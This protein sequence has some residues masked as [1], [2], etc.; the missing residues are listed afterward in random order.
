MSKKDILHESQFIELSDVDLKE[1]LGALWERIKQLKES[2]KS[3]PD[4]QQMTERLKTYREDNF[5]SERKELEKHLKAARYVANA[6]GIK[7]KMPRGGDGNANE[8]N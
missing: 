2:E 7:W 4:V 5:I 1:A 3:D 6:R 8:G